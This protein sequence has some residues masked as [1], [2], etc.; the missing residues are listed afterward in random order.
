MTLSSSLA[1]GAAA[2]SAGGPRVPVKR[3]QK[4]PAVMSLSDFTGGGQGPATLLSP[5]GSVGSVGSAGSA[6]ATRRMP[7]LDKIP[8][9]LKKLFHM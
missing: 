9:N 8:S 4:S 6:D 2:G 3:S 7:S 5:A 1:G